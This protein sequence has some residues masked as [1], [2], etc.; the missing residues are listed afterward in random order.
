M[1][2]P[3]Q[4]AYIHVHGND[5]QGVPN[6]SATQINVCGMILIEYNPRIVTL[7]LC[8]LNQGIMS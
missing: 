5:I 1:A 7:Q 8:K 3:I 2:F 6:A 4:T